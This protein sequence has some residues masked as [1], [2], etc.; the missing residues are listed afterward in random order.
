ML[1]AADVD[2]LERAGRRG[3]QDPE[4][5]DLARLMSEISLS[6]ARRLG[7]DYLAT[8]HID[9]ARAFFSRILTQ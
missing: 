1:P 2:L 7:D 9:V 3:L 6:G 8:R 5:R 4:L